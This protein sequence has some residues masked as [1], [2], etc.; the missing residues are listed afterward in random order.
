MV[1]PNIAVIGCG[2]WGKNVVRTF[3]SLGALRSVCDLR[4]QVLEAAREKYGVQTTSSLME[5]LTDP[6]VEGVAIAAPAVHH[7]HL[8]RQ[9]LEAGK[10]VLVEKPLALHLAEGRHLAR[11]QTQAL[12]C[13]WSV[14]YSNITLQFSS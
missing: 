3:H 13:S 5:V 6:E 12:G 8:V 1:R 2:Y 7:Y 11:L 14:I 4:P 9:A 10:H